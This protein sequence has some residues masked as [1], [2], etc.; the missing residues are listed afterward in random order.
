MAISCLFSPLSI[1]CLLLL[2][3]GGHIQGEKTYVSVPVSS[4]VASPYCTQASKGVKNGTFT[5]VHRAGPCSTNSTKRYSS[6]QALSED[7]LRVASLQEITTSAASQGNETL[8]L[9]SK[10]AVSSRSGAYLGTNSYVVTI[11]FG[12]P[13]TSQTVSFDTASFLSWIQCKPCATTCYPQV[14]PLFDPSLSSTHRKISCAE[15]ACLGLPNHGFSGPICIYEAV[16]RGG[17]STLGLLSTDTFTLNPTT[18]F[19]NFIFGCGLRN[20]NRG[21]FGSSSGILALGRS[22]YS[23][24]SQVG[25]KTKNLFSYCIPSLS[26]TPGFLNIGEPVQSNAVY[27]PMGLRPGAAGRY[28]IDLIGISVGGT[29][30]PIPIDVFRGPGMIIDT[31]TVITR[32]SPAAYNALRSAFRSAMVRFP[33]AQPDSLLDTCYDFSGG[34]TITFPE[35][36]L[37]YSGASVTLPFAG[38]FYLV[39]PRKTCLAFAGNA[40]STDLGI[41]GNTQQKTFEVIYDNIANKIGFAAGACR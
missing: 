34:A 15:P 36:K 29:P 18:A 11:G 4:L 39:S 20:R 32:L 22:P 12:T 8:L 7:M 17:S 3:F 19:P 26:S 35:I 23:L 31:G 16:Y 6:L 2:L 1:L 9:A 24:N 28:F 10:A 13:V 33:L 27:T 37:Q 5:V 40:L 25:I 30:L 41:L 38:V 14:E 21:A